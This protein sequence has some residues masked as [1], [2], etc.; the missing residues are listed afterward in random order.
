MLD[1]ATELFA[2]RGVAASTIALIAAHAGVT[3]AM[4]HY[5]FKNRDQLLDA[6]IDERVLPFVLSVWAEV[7]LA[8][9]ADAIGMVLALADRLMAGL[10]QRPWLPPLWIREIT[11]AGGELRDRMLQRLPLPRMAVFAASI[12]AAQARGDVHP[13]LQPGLVVLSILGLVMLPLAAPAVVD[14]VLQPTAPKPGAALDAAALRRHVHALLAGG[15]K[16]PS[17][18]RSA[19]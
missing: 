17:L 19:L 15:L 7:P 11:A 1:A 13:D 18:A 16:P 2:S 5:Y 6:F 8:P 9:P 12:A 14:K 10:P 4:V 3:G